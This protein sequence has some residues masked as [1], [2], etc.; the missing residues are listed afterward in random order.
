[1]PH[2]DMTIA[3]LRARGVTVSSTEPGV[4]RVEPGPISGVDIVIEPRKQWPSGVG[5][6]GKVA[7]LAEGRAV[8][9]ADDPGFAAGLN[10]YATVATLGV[11][12]RLDLVALPAV[13]SHA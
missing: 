11:L 4:W 6:R 7:G 5:R 10:V 9:F 1:M 8:A 12:A 3:C 13:S 2:I